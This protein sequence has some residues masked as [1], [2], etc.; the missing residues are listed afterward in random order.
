MDALGYISQGQERGKMSDYEIEGESGWVR[1]AQIAGCDDE[2]SAIHKR[3]SGSEGEKKED[4]GAGEEERRADSP[5][6]HGL[7]I[8]LASSCRK[9]GRGGKA[10]IDFTDDFEPAH[11][12]QQVFSFRFLLQD[13][14]PMYQSGPRIPDRT[15]EIGSDA[16]AQSS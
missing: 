4:Q 16:E 7:A 13:F 14:L 2:L 8:L 15:R 12:R 5:C 1:N 9:S 11:P 6:P 3:D 10:T